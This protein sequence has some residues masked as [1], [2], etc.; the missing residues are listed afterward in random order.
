MTPAQRDALVAEK[1]MDGKRAAY[2][3]DFN[4]AWQVVQE[5]CWQRHDPLTLGEDISTKKFGGFVLEVPSDGQRCYASFSREIK[6]GAATPAQAICIAALLTSGENLE[7][8]QELYSVERD[9]RKTLNSL[10]F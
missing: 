7:D 9:G 1:L 10:E 6:V 4:A 2:S 8:G 5:I 3:E